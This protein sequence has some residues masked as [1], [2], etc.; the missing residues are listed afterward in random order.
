MQVSLLCF[1]SHYPR[2]TVKSHL[3]AFPHAPCRLVK[4]SGQL[5]ATRSG[6]LPCSSFHGESSDDGARF[7]RDSLVP[8]WHLTL[9]QSRKDLWPVMPL[10]PQL[11]VLITSS[12]VTGAAAAK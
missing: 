12:V 5:S 1:Q 11:F 2:V 4:S 6:S 8:P 3:S 9:P 10:K 7:P